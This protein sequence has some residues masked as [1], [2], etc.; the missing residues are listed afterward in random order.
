MPGRIP[1]LLVSVSVAL[2]AQ[3]VTALLWLG[4]AANR[5]ETLEAGLDHV[6]S[7]EVRAARL[8]EQTQHLRDALSRIEGKLDTALHGE[9]GK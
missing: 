1:H 3:T 6:S 2:A 8:E 5:L 4:S 7:L 9:G